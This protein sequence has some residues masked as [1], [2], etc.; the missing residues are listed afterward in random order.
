MKVGD[1]RPGQ[2]LSGIVQR[3]NVTIKS[4]SALGDN[5][6]D[7]IYRRQDGSIGQ[8]ILM[9]INMTSI[10]EVGGAKYSFGCEATMFQKHPL[11]YLLADDPGTGHQR[12]QV[13]CQ[14]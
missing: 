4:V 11:R 9:D 7:I 6:I 5:V 13:H 14:P 1:V 10:K 8:Q 12:F 2:I 3:E